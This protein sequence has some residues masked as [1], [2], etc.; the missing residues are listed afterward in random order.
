MSDTALLKKLLEA[1]NAGRGLLRE[2]QET[3][4]K[5]VHEALA[6]LQEDLRA[7]REARLREIAVEEEAFS[8]ELSGRQKRELSAFEDGLA[9]QKISFGDAERELEKILLS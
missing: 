7:A 5:R 4:D 8:R 2:A 1:E 9:Q 6:C 3:A